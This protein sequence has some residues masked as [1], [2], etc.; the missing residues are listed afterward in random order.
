LTAAP[1]KI[2]PTKCPSL[3]ICNATGTMGSFQTIRISDV[4]GGLDT[5]NGVLHAVVHYIEPDMPTASLTGCLG[6]PG[7]VFP[8][9]NFQ[10]GRVIE[11][12]TKFTL[13][14]WPVLHVFK[15]DVAFGGGK[16]QQDYTLTSKTPMCP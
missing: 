6:E 8:L 2:V 4:T 7:G 14:K 11:F 9:S 15:E 10:P 13:D 1:Q 3:P 16:I 5:T 12:D